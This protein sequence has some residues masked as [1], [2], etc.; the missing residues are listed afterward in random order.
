MTTVDGN[1][2]IKKI[3]DD[4]IKPC[5]PTGEEILKAASV[6]L[7]LFG[8]ILDVTVTVEPM[9]N[10]RVRNVFDR[11]LSVSCCLKSIFIIRQ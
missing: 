10:A 8:V 11:K 3:P 1:G 9:T 5:G 2:N 4:Y 7:G 6:S